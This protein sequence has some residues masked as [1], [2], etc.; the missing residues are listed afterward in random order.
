MIFIHEC[1][2]EFSTNAA[3]INPEKCLICTKS[4]TVIILHCQTFVSAL[5]SFQLIPCVLPGLCRIPS[6][7][8]KFQRQL[9]GDG[10]EQALGWE[11]LPSK[12]LD[13]RQQPMQPWIKSLRGHLAFYFMC[14]VVNLAINYYIRN[15]ILD[16]GG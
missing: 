4:Y 13:S 10:I 1:L 9:W 8:H 7:L 16:S 3:L 15:I 5:S 6:V 11:L 12:N 14:V 2:Y